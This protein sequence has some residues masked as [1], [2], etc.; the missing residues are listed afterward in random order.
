MPSCRTR[1]H[2]L[3]LACAA[4]GA[5][6]LP[7]QAQTAFPAQ[8]V[9][10]VVGSEA[11]S[12][13]DVIARS[14]AKELEPLLKQPVVVDNRAGCRQSKGPAWHTGRPTPAVAGRDL[15]TT[16]WLRLTE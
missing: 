14:L 1:R 5:L 16:Y 7:T 9:R 4:A 3:M 13:P 15:T 11:G 6:A 8:P 12:A 10:I 2:A